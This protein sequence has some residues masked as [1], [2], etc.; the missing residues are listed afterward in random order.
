M[1]VL[2]LAVQNSVRPADLG[3]ATSANNYFR[4]IGGSVG[5]AVFGTLFADRLADALADAPAR[6]GAGPCPTR[7]RS[8]R[9]WCT[10]CPPALRDGYIA[11]L[12]RRHAAD[13]PLP[14][15]GARPR[16]A[17]RLLPQGETAG[18][19]HTPPPTRPAKPRDDHGRR[20]VPADARRPTPPASRVCGTV[21]H[22]D[23]TVVPRAALTLID[24]AG[25]Q[26]GRGRQRRG[27]AVRAEH[28]RR[29][30][31]TS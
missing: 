6:T 1:P 29:R 3:T 30:R 16:P 5:A 24:V 14:R 12:R 9:S 22:P 10:R 2:V 13:L 20:T 7:S 4:Q 26:I 15:A 11:G 31:R 18:V 25:Q 28:A 27:R 23:G 21:Q 8:P 17:H 19:P